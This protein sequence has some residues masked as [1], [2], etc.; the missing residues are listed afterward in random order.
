M[1]ATRHLSRDFIYDLVRAVRR[2]VRKLPAHKRLLA[3]AY[4]AIFIFALLLSG[5]PNGTAQARSGTDTAYVTIRAPDEGGSGVL[6]Y[7][8]RP[9]TNKASCKYWVRTANGGYICRG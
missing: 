8:I 6:P 3:G 9:P 1:N 4:A 5:A 7:P 2:Y